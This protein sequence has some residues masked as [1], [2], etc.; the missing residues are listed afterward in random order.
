MSDQ[1]RSA[2]TVDIVTDPSRLFV[3]LMLN[4]ALCGFCGYVA[5]QLEMTP[6][7]R[8]LMIAGVV[9][10]AGMA[11][12]YFRR[13][14]QAG[15]P[16][17]RLAPDHIWIRAGG[18]GLTLPWTHVSGVTRRKINHNTY[19]VLELNNAGR[20][21]LDR[22]ARLSNPWILRNITGERGLP[23]V[24]RD[25]ATRSEDLEQLIAS[26][27]PAWPKSPEAS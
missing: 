6:I 19:V 16:Y 2:K 25:L 3:L 24:T 5:W 21:L 11:L 12:L 22:E 8:T 10:C 15:E 18:D 23:L 9:G 27:L 1:E 13:L 26:Y 14:M 17:L 7:K 4:I 20:A